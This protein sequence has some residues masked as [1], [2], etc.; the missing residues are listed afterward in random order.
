MVT[1]HLH[2][3]SLTLSAVLLLV[4]SVSCS[5]LAGPGR[6]S[7]ERIAPEAARAKLESGQALMVCSYNDARCRN[8][9]IEGALLKS[10]FEEKLASL[11]KDQEIIFY[12]A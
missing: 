10:E 2:L 11:D 12:C 7:I 4:L 5:S 3:A 1:R 6:G 9:L 8:M